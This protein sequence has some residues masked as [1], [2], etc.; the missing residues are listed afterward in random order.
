[1]ACTAT[2]AV[3]DLAAQADDGGC[4][5]ESVQMSDLAA[6]QTGSEDKQV[7]AFFNPGGTLPTPPNPG[8]RKT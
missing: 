2:S 1:M 3:I 5:A 7:C 8:S 6:T 4:N